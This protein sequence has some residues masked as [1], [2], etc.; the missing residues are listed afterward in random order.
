MSG[1]WI[2]IGHQGWASIQ[3]TKEKFCFRVNRPATRQFESV[4][5]A[6]KFNARTL[7]QDW[8]DRPLY[9]SLSGGLD[10]EF[11]ANAFVAEGIEFTPII[12][13]IGKINALEYWYAEYWC[14]QNHVKPH[15]IQVDESEFEKVL[16]A[17]ARRANNTTNQIGITVNFYIADIIEKLQGYYVY[18]AGDINFDSERKQFYCNAVDFATDLYFDGQPSSFFMYTPE[19]V[20]SYIKQFENVEDE[21]ITKLEFYN[22]PPRPKNFWVPEL[23][24]STPKLRE[25]FQIW[26]DRVANPEP[27]R[28]SSYQSIVES[29]QPR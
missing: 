28:F 1:N 21:Q 2:N 14:R 27:H 10:S 13:K 16:P 4:L 6:A 12:L 7:A 20:L 3:A 11:A 26:R 18:A 25:I 22:V 19:F 23:F 9:L 8:N 29:L 5:D 17:F 15:I 24:S